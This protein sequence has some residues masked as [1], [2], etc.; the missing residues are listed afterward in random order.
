[1]RYAPLCNYVQSPLIFL[2]KANYTELIMFVKSESTKL[3]KQSP[4]FKL[5]IGGFTLL[6]VLVALAI[7]A[8][9]LA[10]VVKAVGMQAD[11]SGYLRDK[12]FA[13]WIAVNQLTEQRLQRKWPSIGRGNGKVKMANQ[14]WYWQQTV[15][16][17]LDPDLRRLEIGV[18]N[19]PDADTPLIVVTG[20]LTR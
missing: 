1:V 4:V 3:F 11:Y 9:A 16:D 8:A 13:Q 6:E 7:L 17:T 12:T 19:N 20:F 18:K 5:I 15:F 14:T 10:A 2:K